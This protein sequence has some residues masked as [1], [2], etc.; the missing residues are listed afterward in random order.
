[1]SLHLMR[2]IRSSERRSEGMDVVDKI[3]SKPRD[4]RDNPL[5]RIEIKVEVVE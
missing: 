4:A 5:E 2:N 3:V 1:M